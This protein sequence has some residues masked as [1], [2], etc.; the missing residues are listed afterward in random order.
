MKNSSVHPHNDNNS[1]AG[2]WIRLA[3][4]WIDV[5]IIYS[6]SHILVFCASLI[7]IYI[8]F[9]RA[10]LVLS[11]L[12]FVSLQ[13]WQG[14]TIGKMICGLRITARDKVRSAGYFRILLREVIGKLAIGVVV[15][16]A[17]GRILFP[18]FKIPFILDYVAVILVLFAFLVLYLITKRAWYDV[19]ARTSVLSD[20]H[21]QMERVRAALNIALAVSVV[22]IGIKVGRYATTGS[23]S[24]LDFAPPHSSITIKPYVS[25]LKNDHPDAKEYILQ[26]FDKYDIVVL[27][28]RAHPETTQYDL[29]Y[30]VISD[31][32]FVDNVGNVFSESGTVTIQ[33]Y[34]DEFLNS[35]N[36]TEKEIQEKLVYISTNT[37]FWPWWDKTN[38]NNY[39]SRLYALNQSLPDSS[40]IHH[41]LSDVPFSWEGMTRAKYK[42]F[43]REFLRDR[44]KR[45]ADRIET[46]F[47]EILASDAK[48]KKCLVIMNYRHAFGLVKDPSGKMLGD[49]TCSYLYQAFPERT[50]NILINTV[51]HGNML[52]FLPIQSGKWDA[53]FRAM[54]N[55][56]LGFDFAGSPFGDDSFDMY[57]EKGWSD[58]SYQDVFT[59][60]V[61]FQ[62]LDKHISE[63]GIPG[64]DES[65]KDVY[66]S[67]AKCISDNY[68][69]KVKWEG[70]YFGISENTRQPLDY[71]HFGTFLETVSMILLFPTGLL[72]ALI[73]FSA[74][75]RRSKS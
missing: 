35:D 38:F 45:M 53:A 70:K 52:Q 7:P 49:N 58:Y 14:Q 65:F 4:L 69:S 33:P 26:L 15:P 12:Y 50:A 29:I 44:D 40:R 21:Y 57:P 75:K 20:G 16:I 1:V 37:N 46:R 17:A 32:R 64:L 72:V 39:L 73:A 30:D 2:F 51:I 62:P 43:R 56:S 36:L 28:E 41:Y 19:I 18:D 25:F 13:G 42:S 59:G 9:G 11:I 10:V 66:L 67:R 61:F 71:G 31:Q 60:F 23:I 74:R 8:P 63:L 34:L 22:F 47:K 48:R 55:P 5:F 68:M 6:V 24:T 27:C 54:G 3:A